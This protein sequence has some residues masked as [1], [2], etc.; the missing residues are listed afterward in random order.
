MGI[1]RGLASTIVTDN[2]IYMIDPANQ[3]SYATGSSVA[4]NRAL[5]ASKLAYPNSGSLTNGVLF[6]SDGGGCFEF[7]GADDFIELGSINSSNPLS[8][9]GQ[10]EYSVDIW[11]KPDLEG[12]DYQRIIEKSSSGSSTNGWGI[13]LRPASKVVYMF[14]N[15]GTVMNYTDSA[16]TSTAWTNYTF[17][18]KNTSTKL[19]K[20][21][22]LTHTYVYTKV[23]STTTANMRIG[24][25][26][27]S[28]GREY[29]GKV[30]CIKVYNKQLSEAEVLKNYNALKTRYEL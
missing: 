17:T 21:G 5:D 4:F 9:A 12:D 14:I 3:L 19:Y 29:N 6:S 22:D 7:D 13:A 8:L 2:L 11:I 10:T 1:H 20:N 18:R 15:G 25:W 30:G 24:S 26:N 28:T 23:T 16:L 27:H